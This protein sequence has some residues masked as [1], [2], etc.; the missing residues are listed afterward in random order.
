MVYPLYDGALDG[1]SGKYYID[2]V[3]FQLTEE[4]TLEFDKRFPPKKLH[5]FTSI[6]VLISRLKPGAA[7]AIKKLKLKTLDVIKSKSEREIS[8]L[9]GIDNEAVETICDVMK[10]HNFPWGEKH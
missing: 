6:D 1:I 2:P 3:Y 10:E 5:E 7:D 8:S 4:E 9:P